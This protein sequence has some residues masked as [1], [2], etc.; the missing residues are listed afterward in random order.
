MQHL[1]IISFL[2]FWIFVIYVLN[3]WPKFLHQTISKHGA[4][5]K[6]AY[7][8]YAF[9]ISYS[10]VTYLLLN[11]LWYFEYHQVG[12]L[13]K[14]VIYCVVL[15]QLIFAWVPDSKGTAS[16]VHN[17]AAYMWGLLL[18]LS[19]V[20]LL[21]SAPPSFTSKLFLTIGLLIMSVTSLVI[22]KNKAVHKNLLIYQLIYIGTIHATIIITSYTG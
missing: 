20:I 9:E 8:H 14:L 13:Y 21:F 17:V 3:R 5:N 10:A 15:L 18:Y 7:L 11:L 4:A 6:T 12:A 16:I 1:G 22:I 2:P 19:F